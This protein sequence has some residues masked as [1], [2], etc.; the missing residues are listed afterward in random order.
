MKPRG[1][2]GIVVALAVFL[3]F[4]GS[5]YQVSETSQVIMTQFGTRWGRR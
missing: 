2:L 5:Y 3:I 4:T 1:A